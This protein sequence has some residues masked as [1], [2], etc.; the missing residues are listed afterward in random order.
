MDAT[1]WKVNGEMSKNKIGNSLKWSSAGEIIAKLIVPVTNMLLARILVPEDFGI[2][3]SINMLVSFVDLFTDSGFVKYII[4]SDFEDERE[5]YEFVD[6][7]FWT[8]FSISTLFFILIIIFRNPIA[9]IVGNPG[10]G[11]VIAVAGIQ[12]LL[13]SFSSIQ[14]ALY[15]RFFDFKTLFITRILMAIVPLFITV[16]IAYA[17]KSYWA[18]VIGTLSSAFLNAVVL[19]VKSKWKPGLYYNFYQLK[20]MISFS[21]WSLAEAVAYWLTNWIDV[22]II[23]AAFSAYYLG[24]YKNSL[25][26]VNSLMAM[27]KAS[28]IPV[29][30]STLSRLKNSDLEF[31]NVYFS[32]QRLT[33]CLLI[34]MGIGLFVF[35]DLATNLMF[36]SKWGDASNIVGA[37]ALASCFLILYEGFNG[38]AYKAKG[39]PKILFLF[40]LVYLV[41]MIPICI[42][43]KN[44]GFWAL[45]YTRSAC[46][47]LEDIIGLFYMK[48]Y[49]GFSIRRMLINITV[50]L[51][52][53]LVMGFI[54]YLLKGFN[55]SLLWQFLC[56]GICILVYFSI[57]LGVFK[58][59]IV[60]DLNIFRHNYHFK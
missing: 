56:I 21:V 43:A 48:K 19:T 24:I 4:Q 55:S 34:P 53:A 5:F 26:M 59:F 57:L 10:Y 18:L 23:G 37:W 45:V 46:I 39:L 6:V 20:R 42:W 15:K 41:L 1:I 49:L 8:N 14:T 7:A 11:K 52:S 54:G 28:I 38:E 3:A 16:P 25:N 33:A 29:L 35:R 12:L 51:G 40:Q 50:P 36:G 47:L 58:K 30:F 13:T 44:I 17:T 31:E 2:L 60:S 22:F 32:M 27:V 9:V